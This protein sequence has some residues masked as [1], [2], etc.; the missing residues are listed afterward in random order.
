MKATI[1]RLREGL[2]ALTEVIRCYGDVFGPTCWCEDEC[3]GD[4]ETTVPSTVGLTGW[5]LVTEHADLN[6]DGETLTLWRCGPGTSPNLG[7]GMLH[8]V[9]RRL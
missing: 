9:T 5:V 8:R 7:L 6:P 2:E 4:C 1:D 3:G